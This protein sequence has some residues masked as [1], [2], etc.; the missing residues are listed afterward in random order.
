MIEDL[1][2]S[3]PIDAFKPKIPRVP[4]KNKTS[5]KSTVKKR[6]KLN[7]FLEDKEDKDIIDIG[8]ALATN[9]FTSQ[10]S[11]VR[12]RHTGSIWMDKVYGT[13]KLVCPYPLDGNTHF[14][15]Y[16][17]REDAEKVRDYLILEGWSHG[18]IDLACDECGV[19]RLKQGQ[20]HRKK[21][22]YYIYRATNCQTYYINYKG[23]YYGS[24]PSLEAAMLVRDFLMN[25]GWDKALVPGFA[26]ANGINLYGGCKNFYVTKNNSFTLQHNGVSFGTYKDLRIAMLV[27]DELRSCGW[28]KS[29]LGEIHKRFGIR[30]K[31]NK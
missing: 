5:F 29:K 28:D 6:E 2:V 15:T 25:N 18:N 13:F 19:E 20:S 26:L 31:W 9:K 14:G 16:K 27:R 7:W 21:D 17:S 1:L 10:V 8:T 4:L 3:P 24:Y 12:R 11:N 23:K 30:S 22:D